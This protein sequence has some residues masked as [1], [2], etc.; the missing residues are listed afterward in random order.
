MLLTIVITDVSH[1]C[2]LV[3]RHTLTHTHIYFCVHVYS[4]DSHGPTNQ[5]RRRGHTTRFSHTLQHL[6]GIRRIFC[7][8]VCLT[9]K[10]LRQGWEHSGQPGHINLSKS[11]ATSLLCALYYDAG[12]CSWNIYPSRFLKDGRCHPRSVLTVLSVGSIALITVSQTFSRLHQCVSVPSHLHSFSPNCGAENV[13]GGGKGRR[14]EKGSYSGNRGWYVA[15]S[16][17]ISLSTIDRQLNKKTQQLPMCLHGSWF[18]W[19]QWMAEIQSVPNHGV[20]SGAGSTTSTLGPRQGERGGRVL[21]VL[22]KSPS[23]SAFSL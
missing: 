6:G 21:H 19:K 7:D 23:P 17:W 18:S 20:A 1:H 12:R 11:C 13:E 14:G 16:F 3:C 2:L 4:A 22:W 9:S 15:V 5:N 8:T 10:K